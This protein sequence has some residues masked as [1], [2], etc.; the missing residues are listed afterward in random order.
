MSSSAGTSSPAATPSATPA[1]KTSRPRSWVTNR[2]MIETT[3]LLVACRRTKPPTTSDTPSLDIVSSSSVDQD[4]LADGLVAARRASITAVTAMFSTA[5]TATA[6]MIA[7]LPKAPTI[8]VASGGPA[9]HATETT[10]LVFTT[11]AGL[12]PECR[13]YAK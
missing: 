11:S 2:V 12:A 8:T 10:A 9:T 6:T 5:T 7:S 4:D 13:R 1:H 3:T